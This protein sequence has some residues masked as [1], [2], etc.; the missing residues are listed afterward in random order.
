MAAPAPRS[1]DAVVGERFCTKSQSDP[2]KMDPDTDDLGAPP[3]TA[4]AFTSLLIA[5]VPLGYSWRFLVTG[6]FRR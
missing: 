2:V 6:N 3:K 5:G 4:G 1:D